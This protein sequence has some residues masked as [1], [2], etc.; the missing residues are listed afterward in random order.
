MIRAF[1]L[2]DQAMRAIF[3]AVIFVLIGWMVLELAVRI[4]RSEA[5]SLYVGTPELVGLLALAAEGVLILSV[6]HAF[7]AWSFA[8]PVLMFISLAIYLA[9]YAA[10]GGIAVYFWNSNLWPNSVLGCLLLLAASIVFSA[11]VFRY[12]MSIGPHAGRGFYDFAFV[13]SV[14]TLISVASVP[15]AVWLKHSE[16]TKTRGSFNL[17]RARRLQK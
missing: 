2:S 14:L 4:R 11:A 1:F 3:L 17:L 15:R 16:R 10:V 5:E 6:R 7:Q 13:A 12:R 9:I 8:D